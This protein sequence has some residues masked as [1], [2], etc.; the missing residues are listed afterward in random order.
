M[1]LKDLERQSYWKERNTK[2]RIEINEIDAKNIKDQ[3]NNAL[4]W[5]FEKNLAILTPPPPTKKTRKPI[6][7]KYKWS[8]GVIMKSHMLMKDLEDMKKFLDTY[9]LA[10]LNADDIRNLKRST[11]SNEI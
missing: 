4:T 2:I 6:P 1:H 11:I 3:W 8:L 7:Q 9:G 5:F 10:K